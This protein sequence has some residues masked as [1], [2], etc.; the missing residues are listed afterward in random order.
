[1]SVTKKRIAKRLRPLTVAAFSKDLY[2]GI[3]MTITYQKRA[4]QLSGEA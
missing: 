1:M 3:G 4:W 2:L